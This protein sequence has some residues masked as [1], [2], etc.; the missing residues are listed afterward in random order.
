M[1][2]RQITEKI[3]FEIPGVAKD[4][5]QPVGVRVTKDGKKALVALGP[6]NRVAV[7]DVA[8]KQVEKYLLV[9]Q[10]VWQLAYTPDG[11][12]G[13]STNGNSNDVS[14]IDMETMEVTKSIPVGG[15]PWGVVVSPD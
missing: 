7:V 6:S 13:F 12:L 11:K 1:A 8:S 10:R 15:L 5:I 3:S 4:A 2:T 14:V 9:G